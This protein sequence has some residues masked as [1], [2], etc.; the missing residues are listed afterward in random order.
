MFRSAYIPPDGVANVKSYQ[1]SGT[2]RSLLYRFY[3]VPVIKF[4]INYFP[5]W[6]APNLI[7]FGGLLLNVAA[8]IAIT[9]Y[10]PTLD[11]PMPQ[12]VYLFV[13]FCLHLYQWL[14]NIDGAQARRTKSSSPLGLLFD[15]GTDSICGTMSTITIA[16]VLQTGYTWRL[17][18]LWSCTFIPFVC[19]TWEE[20]Y[21]GTLYLGVINGPS[22]GIFLCA[23]F[24]WLAAYNPLVWV[25]KLGEMIPAAA[26]FPILA[27]QPF[28]IIV[29][30]IGASGVL[31]TILINIF[32]VVST[33]KCTNPFLALSQLLPFAF[34][35]TWAWSWLLFSPSQIFSTNAR[36]VLYGAGFL[37][38][39]LVS[40]LMVA[41]V[42]QLYYRAL[43]FV[44]VPSAI[45]LIACV[46]LPALGVV[47]EPL[48]PE[49][50]ALYVHLAIAF[51][52]WAH[53][54]LSIIRQ[55]TEILGIKVFSIKPNMD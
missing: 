41:H 17:L 31:P 5:T 18:A 25:T 8:H 7:T 3:F 54:A 55:L 43:R 20:Y 21:T 6:L 12:W 50:P 48:L 19:A 49:L 30:L 34:I 16:A 14:D 15:H 46:L 29:I 1:Y 26:A 44:L 51:Y 33:P 37:W 10:N 23:V 11:Q 36:V 4:L 22:D 2:D 45:V 24:A 53:F 52:G 47:S 35:L 28:S 13:G 32:N 42:T 40:K 27:E 39:N 9:Y 38:A